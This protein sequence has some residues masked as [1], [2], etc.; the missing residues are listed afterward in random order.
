MS[1][2]CL[3]GVNVD[4]GATRTDGGL[5]RVRAESGTA[6]ECF[7]A[8]KLRTGFSE[9]CPFNG[10]YG[11]NPT[12]ETILNKDVTPRFPARLAGLGSGRPLT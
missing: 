9:I 7:R 5:N 4:L 2:P 8:R 3:R 6:C 1:Q 11:P 10:S 12:L